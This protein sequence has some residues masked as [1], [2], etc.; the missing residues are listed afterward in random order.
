M[1]V[2]RDTVETPISTT[3]TNLT[4]DALDTRRSLKARDCPFARSNVL[5][6]QASIF[7]SRGTLGSVQK[8]P[9]ASNYGVCPCGLGCGVVTAERVVHARDW[10]WKYQCMHVKESTTYT[11]ETTSHVIGHCDYTPSDIA[12]SS[13]VWRTSNL[14]LPPKG[15]IDSSDSPPISAHRFP[16]QEDRVKPHG[17]SPKLC[18]ECRS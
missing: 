3:F 18:V 12:V 15:R 4:R 13:N 5:Q 17:I 16:N 10:T 11:T 9:L 6:P 14:L 7:D 2:C 8:V 1:V